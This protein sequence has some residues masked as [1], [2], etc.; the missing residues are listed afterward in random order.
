MKTLFDLILPLGAE[1]DVLFDLSKNVIVDGTVLINGFVLQFLKQ[2]F[3]DPK[4]EPLE[5][6]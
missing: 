1:I 6:V 2:V 4:R 5:V 3:R